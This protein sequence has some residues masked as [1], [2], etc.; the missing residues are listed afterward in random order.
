MKKTQYRSTKITILEKTDFLIFERIYFSYR[1]LQGHVRAEK[2][3]Q[4]YVPPAKI[5]RA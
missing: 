2:M 3:Y 4:V 5:R 1:F